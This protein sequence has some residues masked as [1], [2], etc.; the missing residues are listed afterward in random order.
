MIGHEQHTYIFYQSEVEPRFR[1]PI[2]N[3]VVEI[4]SM[5][6]AAQDALMAFLQ[7]ERNLSAAQT[8]YNEART[9]YNELDPDRKF[10]NRHREI[11]EA[12]NGTNN[13]GNPPWQTKT[14]SI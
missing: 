3:E 9:R 13:Q 7:E 11:T 14:S 1:I 10:L 2:D 6:R 12:L 4:P 8:A 5:V